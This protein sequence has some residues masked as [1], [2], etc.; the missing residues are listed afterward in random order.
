MRSGKPTFFHSFAL[1]V[2]APILACAVAVSV[3]VAGLLLWSSQKADHIAMERQERLARHVISDLRRSIAF[4]QESVTV[5]DDSVLNVRR[6]EEG[7]EWANYNL[8]SWMHTY[9][10]HDAA[11]VVDAEGRFHY[12]FSSNGDPEAA[13]GALDASAHSLIEILQAKLRSGDTDDISGRMLAPVA[14]D[15]MVVDGHPAVVS[16]KPI[17]SDTGDIEQTPGE[18]YLHVAIRYLDGSFIEDLQ[19]NYLFEGMRFSWQNDAGASEDSLPLLSDAGDVVGYF[20]W[21]PYRPGTAVLAELTPALL[22]VLALAL[23]TIAALLFVLNQRSRKL[24]AS[25]ARMEYLALHDPLTGLPNR[26]NFEMQLDKTLAAGQRA[27]DMLAVLYLDLDRFKQVN[28]TLGHAAGDGL[29][30]DFAGRLRR[31]TR[32]IDMVARI[33]GDEFVVV[34]PK[35]QDVA[36]AEALCERII[37]SVRQPF[38]ID[39]NQIFVGVSIGVALAPTDGLERTELTRKADIALYHAKS[40]GRSRFAR[41]GAAMDSMLQARR[42]IERDLRVALARKGELQVHY[43]PLHSAADMRITGVEALARW[44]HPQK[45]WIPPAI[46]IP[47][48]EETGLIEAVGDYV[49]R[50]TCQAAAAWPKLAI[51]V[52]VS[53]IELRNPTFAAKVADTLATHDIEPGRLELEVTESALT[54]NAGHCGE[55]VRALRELGVRFALDDFGTGFSS[56]GRLQEFE[57]DRIKIDRSFISGFGKSNGDEAIVQAI[58]DLAHAKGLRTTAEGVET[59]EQGDYLKNIGCDELQGFLLSRAVPPVEIDEMLGLKG[60]RASAA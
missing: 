21:Q 13:Y 34:M 55:N 46:F 17:I 52:N 36:E 42:Q 49:L 39:D 5:W 54:D 12:G 35:M 53:A 16:V 48:A 56:L 23:F 4:D 29:I 2:A 51:A 30:R 44:K 50:E 3:A 60:R 18:E 47:I 19:R 40:G 15:I 59:S 26:S 41:F 38:D 20:V 7:A 57:V 1:R 58:V 25:E 28:D 24:A 45:G 37:D 43:Q 9:F 11:F 6:G 27:G 8:G 22:T 32:D 10:G 14:A 31:L 33:G